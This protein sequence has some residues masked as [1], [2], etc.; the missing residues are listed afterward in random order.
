MSKNNYFEGMQIKKLNT[1]LRREWHSTNYF[2]SPFTNTN[3]TKYPSDFGLPQISFQEAEDTNFQV[4]CMS[5]KV[6]LFKKEII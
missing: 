5:K 4:K 3:Q 1:G 6:K 2:G